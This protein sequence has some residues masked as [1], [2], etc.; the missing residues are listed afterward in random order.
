MR[1]SKIILSQVASWL[2]KG[3]HNQKWGSLALIGIL[4][5]NGF[6]G[7]LLPWRARW[8]RRAHTYVFPVAVQMEFIPIAASIPAME[9]KPL[10]WRD[11]SYSSGSPWIHWVTVGKSLS[12]RGLQFFL[13]VKYR[14][15]LDGLSRSE[16]PIPIHFIT[17]LFLLY[18]IYSVWDKK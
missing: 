9:E 11:Q 1:W 7:G 2:R 14:V 15:G 3:C 16:L 5:L 10:G 12:L 17:A 4:H 6:S 8:P 13:P 18:Y